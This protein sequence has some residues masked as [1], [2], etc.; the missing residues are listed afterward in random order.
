[1]I[2]RLLVVHVVQYSHLF[3]DRPQDLS[4]L[5]R[6]RIGKVKAGVSFLLPPTDLRDQRLSLDCAAVEENVVRVMRLV[7]VVTLLARIQEGWT[8]KA[9]SSLPSW[10]F[11][12]GVLASRT[13]VM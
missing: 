4:S 1:M 9:R 10:R 8:D 7:V 6:P 3:S 13:D 11:E 2:L 12:C 5:L